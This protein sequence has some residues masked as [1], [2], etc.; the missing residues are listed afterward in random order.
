[1]H[2]ISRVLRYPPVCD[3][4]RPQRA[5]KPD[6]FRSSGSIPRRPI[7]IARND[8]AT[9]DHTHPNATSIV[10]Q[11]LPL[12]AITVDFLPPLQPH[13]SPGSLQSSFRIPLLPSRPWVRPAIDFPTCYRHNTLV[14]YRLAFPRQY[15]LRGITNSMQRRAVWCPAPRV[16]YLIRRLVPCSNYASGLSSYTESS[17]ERPY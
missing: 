4:I 15:V 11:F 16:E 3:S 13:L 9:P 14:E 6:Q 8:S 7:S 1:M 2:I 12:G 10:P 17:E 5:N